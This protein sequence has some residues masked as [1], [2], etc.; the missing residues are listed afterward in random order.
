MTSVHQQASTG[1]AWLAPRAANNPE[2]A[3]PEYPQ[4]S[5]YRARYYDQNVGRF[6]NEDPSN[7]F[8][9]SIN[10]Y[11]YVENSP[12]AFKDPNGLQAQPAKPCCDDKKIKDGL[13]Q[14]Q[15]ALNGAKAAQSAI[16]QKYKPCLQKLAGDLDVKCGPP[17]ASTPPGTTNCGYHSPY[18]PGT[19]VI[20][21]Q[22]S[23]G[24]GAC[25]PVKAT[26]AHEM[27][28]SC[29]ENDLAGPNLNSIDQEKQAFG[30]ECQLFGINCACARD[31]KKCGY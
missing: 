2:E 29:Y 4:A 30:I 25:G 19:I 3:A 18:S 12:L 15:Q 31:P 5:Y 17:L 21:P 23:S 22:G 20:T 7:F 24:G 8:S 11:D 26:I 10:F 14:L 28:H 1:E 9:G 16:F 27:V 6:L 13:R